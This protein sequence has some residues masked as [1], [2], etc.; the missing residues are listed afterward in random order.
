VKI[1]HKDKKWVV[2]ISTFPPRECGIATFTQ[3]LMASFDEM[4]NPREEAKVVA[5]NLD[6]TSHY[7]YDAKKVI[8]QIPQPDA[9]HYLKAAEYL[10]SL[11]QVVLVNVQ[12]EFGIYGGVYGANL[13]P[14]LRELK[15]P[16]VITFHTVLPSPDQGRRD[17]VAALNNHV[18]GIIVMTET[19]K[20]ILERDYGIDP[21]KI[22]V[23]PHGIHP[24]SFVDTSRAKRAL[25][26]GKRLTISTFGLLG[27][28]KGIE[29]GIEAMT[30][31]VKEFPDAIYLIIGATHPVVL[32][33]EG[34]SY[35]NSLVKRIRELK[36]ENNVF[37]YNEYLPT[38]KLLEFL[39]ATDI[40]LALS[41]DPNQAVSGTLSYALGCGRPVVST[42]FAQAKEDVTEELG[43]L[44][45]FTDPHQIAAALTA[46]IGDP[47]RRQTMAQKAYFRTRGR[48]W[49]NVVLR[50][51]TEY[52]R[53]VPALGEAEKNIPQINL[54][55]VL[56][57][58]DSFG[59]IQFARLTV[60][61]ISSGYTADDN[62]R[63]LIALT[64]Y[65]ER[66]GKEPVLPVIQ[67]YMSFLEF[68]EQKK[69][70]F[71]NY[72]TAD[73]HIPHDQHIK[74]NLETTSG[75]VLFALAKTASLTK[76]PSAIRDRAAALFSRNMHIADSAIAP[77]SIAYCLKATVAWHAAHPSDE[78]SA[79]AKRL[80][81]KLVAMFEACSGPDWKWFEDILAYSNAVIPESLMDAY[82]LLKDEKYLTI[83]RQALDFLITYS[84]E[85]DVCVPV[86]QNGW[87]R[88]G[89][90]KYRYDQQPEEVAVLVFA[91][92]SMYRVTGEEKYERMRRNAFNW[93]L[94]N[95][96]LRQMVYNQATGGCYDGVG[97]KEVNLN[98]GAESTV[99]Y[100]LA[101]LSFE[102]DESARE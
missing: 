73:R 81:D 58:T 5:M 14:F 79:L 45:D 88:R 102:G 62:A 23:I 3:D 86:G 7:A 60:P 53:I 19:S 95:N 75:R 74:E 20:A 57:L 25:G 51:M 10:N 83:A 100:L 80:A 67:T 76:L 89:G 78:A 96:T 68:V 18:R 26:Y 13:I 24:T 97:E 16:A 39:E 43:I 42:S 99:M 91:L 77:R 40:Y 30:E 29:Y 47:A 22:T 84:F 9:D 71:H 33:N 50:Y 82:A 65:Y 56:D 59:M 44:V 54:S 8:F 70:G 98:Q 90:E 72:V 11:P 1:D 28:G 66:S 32:K 12:H 85:G 64:S 101:R 93:F 31:V 17:T 55:H 36:L 15:K 21:G 2:Y 87:L 94:G 92:K 46:L 38:E 35:R 49:R 52:I 61:D 4:Y 27:R 6:R 63:A 37:F 34:E 69:G 48:T 41:Q